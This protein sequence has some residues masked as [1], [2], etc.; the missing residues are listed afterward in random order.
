MI[1]IYAHLLR[2]RIM[3]NK[4][5]KFLNSSEW[6]P[7]RTLSIYKGL[8]RFWDAPFEVETARKSARKK[9]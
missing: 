4:N 5:K 2:A 9:R 7:Y 3:C 1:Q 8:G 6:L